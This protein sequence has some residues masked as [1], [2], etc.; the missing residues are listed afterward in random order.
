MFLIL[1][2]LFI[3][4]FSEKTELI[5][6]FTLHLKAAVIKEYPSHVTVVAFYCLFGTIQSAAFTL[7]VESD[8]NAW[9]LTSDVEFISVFYTVRPLDKVLVVFLLIY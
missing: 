8:P 2:F 6:L 7:F 4:N 1:F 5:F 9:I 3:Q